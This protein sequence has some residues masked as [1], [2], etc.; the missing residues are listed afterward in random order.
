MFARL[1][2][3]IIGLACAS[4]AALVFL[5]VAVLFDP[6]I[7]GA[8]SHVSSD[9][10]LGLLE[11]LFSDDDPQ[12]AVT[13]LVQLIWTI[14][15]LVCVIPV[16]IIALVGGV[17]RSRSWV[18]YVGLTGVLAAAMPWILRAS[19]FAERGGQMS[20]AEG[21][22]T[23]ILFMT[24]AVAGAVYW[25]VAGRSDGKASPPSGWMNQPRG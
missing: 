4:A 3:T 12:E 17:A 24:G 22:L 8:A 13:T 23:L 20:A 16:T 2:L 18:F 1:L 10:W 9:H 7:Q 5:P 19:R 14:G 25:I 21:H 6:Q 11:N 15:M